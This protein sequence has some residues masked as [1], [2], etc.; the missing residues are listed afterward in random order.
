MKTFCAETFCMRAVDGRR[1][2]LALFRA[3]PV[4]GPSVIFPLSQSPPA[5]YQFH[6]A[7]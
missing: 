7:D 4:T 1:A 6:A 3:S 5:G 2:F